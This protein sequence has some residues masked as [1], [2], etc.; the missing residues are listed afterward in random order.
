MHCCRV[1]VSVPAETVGVAIGL[2]SSVVGLPLARRRV[3]PNRWY[4]LRLGMYAGRRIA[5][6]L[7]D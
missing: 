4:G 3:P 1:R 6:R 5:A 2:L 7:L